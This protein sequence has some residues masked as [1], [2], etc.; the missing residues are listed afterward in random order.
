MSNDVLNPIG[1]AVFNDSGNSDKRASAWG[2][3]GKRLA[4]FDFGRVPRDWAEHQGAC[5]C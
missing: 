2:V 5:F 4:P 3:A 1:R